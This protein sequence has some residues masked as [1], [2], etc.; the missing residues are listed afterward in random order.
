MGGIVV[1]RA[2]TSPPSN[3]AS[4]RSSTLAAADKTGRESSHYLLGCGCER[5]SKRGIYPTGSSELIARCAK[6][7]RS[8][9]HPADG[10][11]LLIASA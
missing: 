8:A 6:N 11:F 4:K 2:H 7:E 10:Y 1:K 5:C 3:P 9:P